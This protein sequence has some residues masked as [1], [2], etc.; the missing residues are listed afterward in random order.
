MNPHI[1]LILDGWGY[2]PEQSCNAIA[3]AKTPY[4][5]K[6]LQQPLTLLEASGPAV[7]LPVNQMGSSEV[8]H[9]TIGYGQ[10]VKQDLDYLNH[11]LKSL[12]HCQILPSHNNLHII[13]C[14]SE[15]GVHAHI[16]HLKHICRLM[17]NRPIFIHAILD[18]RDT[19]MNASTHDLPAL[20]EWLAIHA[21]HAKIVDCIGRFYAMD[22]DNNLDRTI[23]ATQLYFEGKAKYHA[24]NISEALQ[25]INNQ[26]DEYCP[27]L[28]IDTEQAIKPEDAILFL[29]FR[30]DRMCQLVDACARKH[31]TSQMMSL[32]AYQSPKLTSTI[33]SIFEKKPLKNGLTESLSTQGIRQQKIAESEKFAHVTYF[34]NGRHTEPFSNE[35]WITIPSPKTESYAL[36]PHMRTKEIIDSVL[37]SL[38]NREA[39]FYVVN[40]AAADMVGHT[41]DWQA[42]LSAIECIDDQLG[43]LIA[44]AIESDA[45]LYIT[46]D[47]GNADQMGQPHQ[48]C[49]SHSLNPVPFIM[50]PTPKKT[51]SKHGT[52]SQIAATIMH[53][54][55]IRPPDHMD[56]SLFD[57]HK[58]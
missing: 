43:R 35:K 51:L 25:W 1:L 38:K 30:A 57:E 22:R 20:T 28:I 55:G 12:S 19:A 40:I 32:M 52:L 44:A 13:M 29:N 5:D 54:M 36:I 53:T 6:L 14:L 17:P 9:M 15:G 7:G 50:Y 56:P 46:A 37:Q 4:Y 10:I 45:Q 42:T 24:H 49:T 23:K 39:D 2:T 34:F 31:N 47:H 58:I 3:Q 16:N 48:P 27:P 26:S 33:P 11:E 18:G 41:G 21:P 8:G